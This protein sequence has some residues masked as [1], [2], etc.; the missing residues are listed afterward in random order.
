MVRFICSDC[1]KEKLTDIECHGHR[2]SY[3]MESF[4]CIDCE[5]DLSDKE[6][7]ECVPKCCHKTMQVIDEAG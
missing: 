3:V 1:G 2:I 4:M 7:D 6:I 5:R